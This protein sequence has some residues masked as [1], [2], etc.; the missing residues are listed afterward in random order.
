[1]SRFDKEVFAALIYGLSVDEVIA[2][3]DLELNQLLAS[4][5]DKPKD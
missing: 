1:M 2:L 4:S 5:L 3:S